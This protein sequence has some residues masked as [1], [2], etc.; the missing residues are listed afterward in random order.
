MNGTT[1]VL[2]SAS[3][4]FK[5]T[6]LGKLCLVPGAGAGGVLLNTT[7]ASYQ[8]ATQVTLAAVS[9][10]AVSGGTAGQVSF[11]TDDTAGWVAVKNAALAGDRV[12]IP[13]GF[14]FVT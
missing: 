13:D 10:T 7:I 4:L 1:A 14:T 3:G 12:L 9:Q 8:S 6:D 5:S 2:I 11:G